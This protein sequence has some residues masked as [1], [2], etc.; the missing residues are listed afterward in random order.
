M[1][2][3]QQR[4]LKAKMVEKDI[5]VNEMSYKLGI[6]PTSFWRKQRVTDFTRKELIVIKE[7]LRLTAD[8]VISIFF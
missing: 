4:L 6:N 2:D 8:D 7:A 3:K 5:N 1:T